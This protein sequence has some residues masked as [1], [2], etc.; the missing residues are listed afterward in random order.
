MRKLPK[1]IE[2][3][4]HKKIQTQ[5]D[6]PFVSL[7]ITR[8]KMP[9]QDSGYWTVEEIRT[10]E[11]VGDIA[12]AGKREKPFG[13]PTK[14]YE[15]HIEN[16]IVKT[17]FR[18]FP[19]LERLGWIESETLEPG[20]SVAICFDVDFIHRRRLWRVA[21]VGEP[22]L[23]WVDLAGYIK[24]KRWGALLS[25]LEIVAEGAKSVAVVRAWKNAAVGV[26]LG[27]I[28]AYV[29]TDNKVYYKQLI[30]GELS[31]E[32][33][34]EQSENTKSVSLMLTNDY[35]V[36][37]VRTHNGGTTYHLTRRYW[38]GMA[39]ERQAI[40]AVLGARVDVIKVSHER[41]LPVERIDIAVDAR[42]AAARVIEFAAESAVNELFTVIKVFFT[43]NI[44][45]TNFEEIKNSISLK[46]SR[47]VSFSVISVNIEGKTLTII[48]NDFSAVKDHIDIK[49]SGQVLFAL[50]DNLPFYL[51]KDTILQLIP[52]FPM[53][54]VDVKEKIDISIEANVLATEVTPVLVSSDRESVNVS[55]G[56]IITP[57]KTGMS[58][59]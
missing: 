32:Y 52:V 6:A 16:G 55:V 41:V 57:I 15:I 28:I 10:L 26:E 48:S 35:R 29:K 27:M 38:S 1:E 25:E 18:V 43:H 42:V 34:L 8:P 36:G 49:F 24:M 14:L 19:D 47:G 5:E 22:F 40:D 13:R 56:A 53:V 23:F 21:T 3:K 31:N 46:D 54:E 39:V 12:V 44:G 45:N 59:L 20:T 50:N 33:L 17:A 37:F 58:P 30:N 11:G 7:E 2:S 51:P 4:I 9:I